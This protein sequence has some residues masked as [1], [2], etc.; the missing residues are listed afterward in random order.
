VIW[1]ALGTLQVELSTRTSNDIT[2]CIAR[3]LRSNASDDDR[4]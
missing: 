1:H 2:D 3:C 4:S